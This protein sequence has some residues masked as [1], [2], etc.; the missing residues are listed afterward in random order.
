MGTSWV[1]EGDIKGFF[2]NID[3]EILLKLL[4]KRIDDGRFVE[5]VK[6]FLKAGYMEFKEIHNSLSGIPQGGIISPI[7]A[8]ISCMN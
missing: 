1:I 6:R 7:L 2:D 8:N 5:L 4:S 3:H